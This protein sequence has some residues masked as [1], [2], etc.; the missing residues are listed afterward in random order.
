[1][2][3]VPWC[4]FSRVIAMSTMVLTAAFEVLLVS[5]TGKTTGTHRSGDV[6]LHSS[7]QPY[8]LIHVYVIYIHLRAHARVAVTGVLPPL[9]VGHEWRWFST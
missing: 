1:M 5:S 8:L 6:H 9:P 3:I 4:A 7:K 2:R